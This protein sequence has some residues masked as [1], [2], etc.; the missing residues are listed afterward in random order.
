MYVIHDWCS[1]NSTMRQTC[2]QLIFVDT[3]LANDFRLDAA[4]HS[5]KR[6]KIKSSDLSVALCVASMSFSK[7]LYR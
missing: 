2:Q 1:S 5:D 7:P 4:F 3:K 6:Y